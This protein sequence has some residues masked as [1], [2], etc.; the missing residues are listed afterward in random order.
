MKTKLIKS[1][2]IKKLV[3]ETSGKRTS[4]EFLMALDQ[5]VER[6]VLRAAE[7]HNG[8]RKTLDASVAAHTVGPR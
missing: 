5:H 6:A 1:S 7:E 3:K 2:A 4:K 8:G